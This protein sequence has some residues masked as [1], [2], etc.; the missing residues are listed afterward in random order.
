M[1]AYTIFRVYIHVKC[2]GWICYF[3]SYAA[4]NKECYNYNNC[5]AYSSQFCFHHT[6]FVR[7]MY[8]ML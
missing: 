4:E 8:E 2:K 7:N 5:Y 6:L 3:S 1:S